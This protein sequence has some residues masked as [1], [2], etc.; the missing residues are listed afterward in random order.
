MTIISTRPWDISLLVSLNRNTNIATALRSW[1][2]DKRGHYR[3]TP[4]IG[5]A[6]T[7]DT[8]PHRTRQSP[9][10]ALAASSF[11]LYGNAG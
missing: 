7:H 11:G 2:L 5:S 10:A 6:P 9:F 1:P 4:P 8:P 3:V